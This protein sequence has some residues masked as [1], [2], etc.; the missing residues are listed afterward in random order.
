MTETLRTWGNGIGVRLPGPML[1]QLG[2]KEGALV[3]VL[4]EGDHLVIHRRGLIPRRG[5]GMRH[6]PRLNRDTYGNLGRR[7]PRV[8][9]PLNQNDRVKLR[10]RRVLARSRPP[11]AAS[12]LRVGAFIVA[13]VT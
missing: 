1:E 4:V 10:P 11:C 2:P 3:D 8:L 5:V 12:H 7:H 9:T 6:F 13:Q